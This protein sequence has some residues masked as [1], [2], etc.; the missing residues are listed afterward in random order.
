VDVLTSAAKV[1]SLMGRLGEAPPPGRSVES[2]SEGRSGTPAFDDCE[3]SPCDESVFMIDDH[4]LNDPGDAGSD[5][6]CARVIREDS[7][8]MF[9]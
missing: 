6:S 1:S 9:R 3:A 5:D 4:P 7:K 2:F 8:N